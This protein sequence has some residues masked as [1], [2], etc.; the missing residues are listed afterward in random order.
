LKF[1]YKHRYPQIWGMRGAGAL[2]PNISSWIW[3]FRS[4]L[5]LFKLSSSKS[6]RWWTVLYLPASG[7]DRHQPWC[8]IMKQQI[9]VSSIKPSCCSEVALSLVVLV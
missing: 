6:S 8:N 4:V 9:T 1:W 7:H 3:W 2:F 5:I